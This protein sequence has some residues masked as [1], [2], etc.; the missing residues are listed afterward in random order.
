MRA[1]MI[2]ISRCEKCALVMIKPPGHFGTVRI[3]EIDDDVLI[4]VKQAVY[5]RLRGAVRHSRE[6]EF[7][8]GVE[9]FFIEAVEKRGGSCPI[10]AAV[11]KTQPDA[12][13]VGAMGPFS[14]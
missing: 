5:P 3:F 6:T 8:V 4:A 1:E 14:F 11:M 12:G 13:H 9:F 10:K 2:G 7:R